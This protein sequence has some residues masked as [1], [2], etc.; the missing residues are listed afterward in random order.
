MDRVDESLRP[1]LERLERNVVEWASF[2]RETI[3]VG[4]F[5]ALLDP[6][7]DLVYLNY[8]VPVAPLGPWP[9]IAEALGYLRMAF[10]VRRRT[11]R[12]EFTRELW[13]ELAPALER[14]GLRLEARQPTM[15]VDAG[16]F[17]PRSS[18]AVTVR[19]L[20]PGHAAEEI[21]EFFRIRDVSFGVADAVDRSAEASDLL[22]RM[23]SGNLRAAIALAD[24]VR[25]GVGCTT[26]VAGVAELAGVGTLAEFRRRGVAATL[27]SGLVRDHF[28]RGG[29]LVWLSAGD[30][31]AEAVY[32]RLGFRVVATHV[33]YIDAG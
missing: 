13:P 20:E 24:G 15:L 26:P 5:R 30:A 3:D 16:S 23:R 10:G 33:N 8:A 31:T 22:A 28:A 17:T 12:F 2:G 14:G 21:A 9:A 18:A 6:A 32:R 1:T 29:D 25:A 7:T 4:P 27:S 19:W 11:L